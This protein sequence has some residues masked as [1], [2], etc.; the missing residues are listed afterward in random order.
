MNLRTISVA[1]GAGITAFMLVAVSVIE[2]LPFEFSAL[3]GL[4]VGLLAGVIVLGGILVKY[5]VISET[6]QQLTAA[7]A[8]FGYAIV[9]LLGVSYV[10]LGGL[11]SRIT[12]ELMIGIGIATAIAVYLGARLG[13]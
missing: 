13:D 1:V 7:L 4:P 2:L 8:G 5:Q 3:V 11:R 6:A 12:V 10:N 9:V